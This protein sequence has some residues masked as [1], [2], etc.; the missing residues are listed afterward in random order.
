SQGGSRITSRPPSAT[1]TARCTPRS[2]TIPRCGSRSR[3][4]AAKCTSRQSAGSRLTGPKEG[5][6][7]NDV[8]IPWVDDLMEILEHAES[9]EELLEHTRMAMYQDR[10]FAFTPKGE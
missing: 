10:I 8:A 3:S 5:K 4:G 9:P 6:P 7:K 2:S 1:A